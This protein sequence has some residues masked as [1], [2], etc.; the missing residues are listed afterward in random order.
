ML[1]ATAKSVRIRFDKYIRIL[2]ILLYV[3]F[4]N[5]SSGVPL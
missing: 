2:F 4:C 5:V 3:M 1:E